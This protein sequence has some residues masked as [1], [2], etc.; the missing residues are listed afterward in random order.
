MPHTLKPPNVKNIFLSPHTSECYSTSLLYK[1]HTGADIFPAESH[2]L[3]FKAGTKF[4]SIVGK[5]M[6]MM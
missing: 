6:Q 1:E 4:K 3:L 5:E 2:H